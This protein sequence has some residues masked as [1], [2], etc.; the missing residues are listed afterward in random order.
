MHLNGIAAAV[1]AGVIAAGGTPVVFPVIGICDGIAMGHGGMKYSLPS[2]ELIA[3]SVESM[4]AAHAFDG[5]VLIPNCD[6]IVPGMLMG[7]ARANIPS[8]VISGGPMLPGRLRGKNVGF[9]TMS[10]A[11]GAVK[12]GKMTACELAE[13]ENKACPGCGSCSG[14]FTANSMNCLTEALGMA[15]SGNGTIP[16][17]Y[18]E[19][20]R[21]AKTTGQQIMALVHKQLLPRMILTRD[22][23][24]NALSLD[25][26]IGA[27]SNSLLHLMAI[28]AESGADFGL[29]TVAEI[30]NT[31]PNLCRLNPAGDY[32]VLDL[33][34]AGGV[35]A[36]LAELAKVNLIRGKAIT[37]AD[38][39]LSDMYAHAE[40]L[41]EEVIR[42]I[43]NPHSKTGGL[44]VLYGNIAEE[45]CVVKRSAVDARMLTHRGPARVFDNEENAVAAI[46]G[47]LIN[48][49]DVVIIRYEGPKGGPGMREMLY[50]TS[51]LAGMG[52]G[53]EVAL[54]TDG[55]FSGA[56]RGASIGHVSPE[57]AEGGRI[58]LVQEGDL[59]DIDIP[60]GRINAD[61]TPKEFQNRMKKWEPRDDAVGGY[62][63]RYRDLVTSAAKGAVMKRRNG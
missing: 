32:T 21:L 50:P 60:K 1:K 30:S 45:G 14:M 33:Y 59:I 24:L 2:R 28:A 55:R 15:L 25:M 46:S 39:K 3:D 9:A 13:L 63:A 44:A 43:D 31:V 37:V 62:L 18:S 16:A 61:V 41:N 58:A 23:F 49:G 54:I 47:G 6:K 7:A 51:T 38:K 4:V 36:V 8:I 17:V 10:E 56:T 19:R 5:L 52:L 22:A 48:P 40:N 35:P 42:P 27:S 12:A 26:A 20:I 29:E 53:A 57:A 34:E 11:V